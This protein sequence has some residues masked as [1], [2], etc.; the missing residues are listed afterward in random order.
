MCRVGGDLDYFTLTWSLCVRFQREKGKNFFATFDNFS[1]N[2]L[3][4]YAIFLQKRLGC[5][6]VTAILSWGGCGR[7]WVQDEINLWLRLRL[8]WG[9][10]EVKLT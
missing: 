1:F 10:V 9:C 2:F 4:S 8:S 6:Y 7:D 5:F 3:Q